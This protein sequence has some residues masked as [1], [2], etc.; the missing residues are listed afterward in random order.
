MAPSASHFARLS[1]CHDGMTERK[2]LEAMSFES[3]TM[4]LCPYK[5]P[6]S[7]SELAKY[8]QKDIN[9]EGFV[10]AQRIMRNVVFIISLHA[11]I[12]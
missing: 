7:H 12:T 4:A 5:F 2:K 6:F 8:V 1:I 9:C 3:R 10:H 11:D